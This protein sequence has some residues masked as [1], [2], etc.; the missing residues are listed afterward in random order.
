[1][2]WFVPILIFCAR[3]FDVSIGTTRM[4]FVINGHRWIA[5]VLG[6]FE[7]LVWAL[8]I[9]GVVKYL[10]EW[11][12]LVSYAGGFACGTL[13]GMTIEDRIAVG[14]RTIRVLNSDSSINVSA[15]LR[16]RDYRVTRVEASGKNGPVEMA[17]L[18]VRRRALARTLRILDEVAPEAFVTIDRTDRASGQCFREV[19][20]VRPGAWLRGMSVRK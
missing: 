12:A 11:T 19:R 18:V 2:E 15:S 17:F 10:G 20:S 7:V 8:A 1:M 4:I 14:Y 3:I 13:V 6:F 16:A 9:G 5:A